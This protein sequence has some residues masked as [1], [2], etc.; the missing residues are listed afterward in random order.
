MHIDDLHTL[1]KRRKSENCRF[2]H[3]IAIISKKRQISDFDKKYIE[4][5][6][7]EFRG[8]SPPVTPLPWPWDPY[9]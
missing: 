9:P 3:L 6:I 2:A 4:A 7:S 8:A 5:N 1:A